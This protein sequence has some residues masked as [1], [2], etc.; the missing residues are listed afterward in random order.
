MA[1]FRRHPPANLRLVPAA[2]AAGLRFAEASANHTIGPHEEL[3]TAREVGERLGVRPRWVT[4]KWNEGVLPGYRLPGSNRL[5]FLWPEI[6]A[7]LE[8]HGGQ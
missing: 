1:R 4:D 3:L 5:R 7:C 8:R 6:L 2:E